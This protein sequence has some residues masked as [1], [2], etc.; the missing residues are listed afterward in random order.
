M[1]TD[2]TR[3][4]DSG[5]VALAEAERIALEW[6]DTVAE[7]LGTTDRDHAYRLLRA[8]LRA[9]R[10]RLEIDGAAHL[11][12][13]L[14]LL[15]RGVWFDGWRPAQVPVRYGPEDLVA[16]VSREARVAPS[17][18]RRAIPLVT[19]ALDRRWATE[20]TDHLL[21]QLPGSLRELLASGAGARHDQPLADRSGEPDA[22]GTTEPADR[23]EALERKVD[24][25]VEALRALLHGFESPPTEE[26]AGGR[27]VE[28]AHRAHRILLGPGAQ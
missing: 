24:T 3:H 4:V 20:Q 9:V 8:W 15:L 11:A 5:V 26:P 14:P 1:T 17:E 12:A 16:V 19:R 6:V 22:S 7:A 23:L 2:T 27:T 21:A 28:A 25:V 10:D 18:A 13:Q